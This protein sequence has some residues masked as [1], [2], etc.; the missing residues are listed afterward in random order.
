M[1][2]NT[3]V[4]KESQEILD[5]IAEEEGETKVEET[6]V[7][8]ETPDKPEEELKEPEEE[9]PKEPEKESEDDSKPVEKIERPV[10][11]MPIAKYQKKKDKWQADIAERD[12]KIAE[13][14][15]RATKAEANT[16]EAKKIVS[17]TKA[18]S[19]KYNVD[20]DLLSDLTGVITKNIGRTDPKIDALLAREE[21][22]KQ[23]NAFDDEV[24]TL[25]DDNSLS[26]DDRE[27]IKSSKK[28]IKELAFTEENKNSSVY[29]IF[30]R[31]IKPTM[32]GKKSAEVSKGG[33]KGDLVDY[34]KVTEDDIDKMSGKEFDKYSEY[35]EKKHSRPRF[36]VTN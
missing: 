22:A 34:D 17:E 18:L 20:E 23:D 3:G 14:E 25:L 35:M 19:E 5:E 26:D 30:F 28:E 27:G 4:D 33:T 36:T 1:T 15:E 8:T 32:T 12:A 10:R 16:P 11:A 31:K 13:L 2:T 6:K 21:Q 7:E 29:E 24:K 9:T